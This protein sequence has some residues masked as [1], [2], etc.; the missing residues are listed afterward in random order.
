MNFTDCDSVNK[1]TRIKC[2][3][4]CKETTDITEEQ[5]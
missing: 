2:K 3:W 1:N 5:K 4:Q